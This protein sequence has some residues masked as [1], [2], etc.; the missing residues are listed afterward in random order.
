MEKISFLKIPGLVILPSPYR[1]Q[2]D[3]LMVPWK[4]SIVMEEMNVVKNDGGR[5]PSQQELEKELSD[6]LA[7]KYGNR[8]KII[9]PFVVPKKDEEGGREQLG[10]SKATGCPCLMDC[11]RSWNRIWT[12]LL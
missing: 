2:K 7:K 3:N 1:F 10:L 5:V 11:R 9:S 6:Y 8:V 12:G 4:R